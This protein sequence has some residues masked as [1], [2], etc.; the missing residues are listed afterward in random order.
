MIQLRYSRQDEILGYIERTAR[1]RG[2]LDLV[3]TGVEVAAAAYDEHRGGCGAE[4]GLRDREIGAADD[5]VGEQEHA[6]SL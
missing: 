1:E 4:Q 3:R 2:V 5:A 6:P